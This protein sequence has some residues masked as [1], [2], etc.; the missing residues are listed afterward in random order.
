VQGALVSIAWPTTR[1]PAW[2]VAFAGG[3]ARV[4]D[5]SGRASL[6]PAPRGGGARLMRRLHD[7][8]G[9]GLVWQILIFVA[10]LIPAALAVTGIVMWLRSRGWRAALAA[11]RKQAT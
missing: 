9:M 5:A 6:A 3:E 11:K 2:H 7:G 8:T 1:D 4:D 10:G